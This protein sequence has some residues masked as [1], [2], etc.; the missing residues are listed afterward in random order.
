MPSGCVIP[1]PWGC[2]C[3]M[4]LYMPGRPHFWFHFWFVAICAFFFSSASLIFLH[5]VLDSLVTIITFDLSVDPVIFYSY[6][7]SHCCCWF[8]L[9]HKQWSYGVESLVEHHYS[10]LF[11]YWCQLV[12]QPPDV[13]D[14]NTQ[15]SGLGDVGVLLT[16]GSMPFFSVFRLNTHSW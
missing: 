15:C 12:G 3:R 5:H 8:Y 7:S 9:L 6:V 4:L 2:R 13:W 1:T 11:E 16:F 10:V 14:A